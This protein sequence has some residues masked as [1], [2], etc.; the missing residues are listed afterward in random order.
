MSLNEV[1]ISPWNIT[2]FKFDSILESTLTP[3]VSSIDEVKTLINGPQILLGHFEVTGKPRDT[4]L[5][6][7]N[8]GK[9]VAFVNDHNLGR[10]WPLIGPQMTLYVPAAYLKEGKNTLVLVELE[11]VPENRKINFQTI[12]VLDYPKNVTKVE[13]VP[14]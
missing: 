13:R 1:T 2:G 9:G 10:Y 4:Y 7:A 14:A 11:Y 6:T 8:W 3:I 12:A 5:N